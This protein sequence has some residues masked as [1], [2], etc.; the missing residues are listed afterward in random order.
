MAD[1]RLAVSTLGGA[2]TLEGS[3][4]A[5]AST[6]VVVMTGIKTAAPSSGLPASTLVQVVAVPVVP[7]GVVLNDSVGVIEYA[8]E[9]LVIS[10]IPQQTGGTPFP[11]EDSTYRLTLVPI[12]VWRAGNA[13]LTPPYTAY[14]KVT[15]TYSDGRQIARKIRPLSGGGGIQ[16]LSSILV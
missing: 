16:T 4:S 12:D 7:A 14:W 3:A 15:E 10:G 8:V 5:A 6:I 2:D 9:G 1:F 13:L 11:A